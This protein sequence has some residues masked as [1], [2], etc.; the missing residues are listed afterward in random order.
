[1]SY[2]QNIDVFNPLKLEICKLLTTKKSKFYTHTYNP[3]SIIQNIKDYNDP[4]LDTFIKNNL[5]DIRT[6]IGKKNY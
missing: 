4:E 2:T 5:F 3:T 6:L 1:M